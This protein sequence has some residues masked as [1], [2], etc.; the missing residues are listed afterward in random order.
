M[1]P[2][3]AL[4]GWGESFLV[5]PSFWWWPTM[6]GI[7]Q[8]KAVSLQSLPPLSHGPLPSVCV[9]IHLPCVCVCV[10]QLTL[11]CQRVQDSIDVLL[12]GLELPGQITRCGGLPVPKLIQEL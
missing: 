4:G 9:C 5:S 2:L 11:L 10:V 1:L 8:F 7:S 6:L 12:W 3:E